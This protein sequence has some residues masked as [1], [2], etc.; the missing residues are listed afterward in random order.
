MSGPFPRQV[1]PLVLVSAFVAGV[2]AVLP[3]PPRARC[4]AVGLAV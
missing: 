1:P 2:S 3:R 4:A